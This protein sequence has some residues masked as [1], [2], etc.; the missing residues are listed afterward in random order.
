VREDLC[1]IRFQNSSDW[2]VQKE[3][4]EVRPKRKRANAKEPLSL[5]QPKEVEEYF[6]PVD[7]ILYGEDLDVFMQR[8]RSSRCQ[9]SGV[10][11]RTHS[12]Y[13][14]GVHQTLVQAGWK[15]KISRA[16]HH[17]DET[18]SASRLL[19]SHINLYL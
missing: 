18:R 1:N 5:D 13:P 11:D 16:C 4:E 8:M 17:I 2:I 6:P 14:V 7:W 9:L 12:F 15:S 10:Q 3:A 19:A